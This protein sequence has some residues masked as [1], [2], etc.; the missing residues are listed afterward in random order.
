LVGDTFQEP[1]FGTG[2]LSNV[3]LLAFVVCHDSTEDC[4]CLIVLGEALNEIVGT[5][6]GGGGGGGGGGC[7]GG[8]GTGAGGGG[9]GA[10]AGVGAGVGA[11][12]GAGVPVEVET[13]LGAAAL[14]SEAVGTPAQPRARVSKHRSATSPGMFKPAHFVFLLCPLTRRQQRSLCSAVVSFMC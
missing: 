8:A 10:G 1:L 3:T 11:G 5:G 4:P 6:A 14:F 9:G 13:P 12:A 2:V 7:G